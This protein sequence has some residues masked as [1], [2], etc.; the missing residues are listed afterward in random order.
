[1]SL[2]TQA[3][4]V[5]TSDQN[6]SVVEHGKSKLPSILSEKYRYIEELGSGAQAT[7]VLA[8]RLSDGER[9]AIKSLHI[10]NVDDW[11]QIE[12][13]ERECNT[14]ASI[15]IEGIPKYYEHISDLDGEQPQLHLIQSYIE[16]ENLAVRMAKGYRFTD[17]K[18]LEIMRALLKTIDSLHRLHP[19]VY[20]RDIKPSNIIV[21]PDNKYYLIDF[22]TV[23]SVAKSGATIVGTLGY[24]APEQLLG[25]VGASSDTYAIAATIFHLLT[26]ISPNDV[27]SD[28]LERKIRPHLDNCPAYLADIIVKMMHSDPKNR[29]AKPQKI[30]KMLDERQT[31]SDP[32]AYEDDDQRDNEIQCLLRLEGLMREREATIDQDLI[33]EERRR[34]FS[35]GVSK[36]DSYEEELEDEPR[37]DSSVRLSI[38]FLLMFISFIISFASGHTF[39]LVLAGTFFMIMVY[40]IFSDIKRATDD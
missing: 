26:G 28:G 35:R 5:N 3:H 33:W 34:R 27:A 15:D 9:V 16:G 40:T 37:E 32:E 12:L 21:T 18:I 36:E 1:M 29:L 4:S 6:V 10:S 39:F 19:P 8:E 31:I 7:T 24:M 17:E 14:L 25:N 20:H 38:L 23:A 22:G 13:F 2:A 11:K 30:L